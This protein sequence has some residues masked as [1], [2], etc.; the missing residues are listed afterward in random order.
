MRGAGGMKVRFMMMYAG[1][2]WFFF[3]FLYIK[4][5]GNV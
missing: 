3:Y 5:R 4:K 1:G 2:L